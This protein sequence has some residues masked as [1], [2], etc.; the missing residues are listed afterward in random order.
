MDIPTLFYRQSSDDGLPNT[1][2]TSNLKKMYDPTLVFASN[3]EIMD[4]PTVFY[5]Q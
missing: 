2:F 5:W 3:Y 1:G 4:D